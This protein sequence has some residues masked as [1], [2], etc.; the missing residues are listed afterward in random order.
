M[1][2]YYSYIMCAQACADHQI[3]TERYLIVS[4]KKAQNCF[5]YIIYSHTLL[6]YRHMS[7]ITV[8]ML[9]V[10][11]IN[12]PYYYNNTDSILQCLASYSR[13]TVLIDISI[14]VLFKFAALHIVISQYFCFDFIPAYFLSCVHAS[15]FQL[16]LLWLL[17]IKFSAIKY[18]L[19]SSLKQMFNKFFNVSISVCEGLLLPVTCCVC[20][21]C[22]CRC[23]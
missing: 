20:D 8:N 2:F 6:G 21:L 12:K 4:K 7:H 5:F 22:D 17:L 15:C 13:I 9:Q 16:V 18:T 1:T 23:R 14:I 3:P 10:V 11:Y 19:F